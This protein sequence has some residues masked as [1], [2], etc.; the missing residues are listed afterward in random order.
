MKFKF[1]NLLSESCTIKTA[2]STAENQFT[3]V[4]KLIEIYD[5]KKKIKN[6]YNKAKEQYFPCVKH[7]NCREQI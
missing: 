4:S 2:D 7:K 1:V 6:I 5:F 3:L